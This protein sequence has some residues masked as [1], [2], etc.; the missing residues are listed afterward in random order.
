MLDTMSWRRTIIADTNPRNFGGA[1]LTFTVARKPG[2]RIFIEEGEGVIPFGII[3]EY[4]VTT[5]QINVLRETDGK[6]MGSVVPLAH[7]TQLD[8]S[9]HIE[10]NSRIEVAELLMLIMIMIL[11]SLS[12]KIVRQ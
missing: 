9:N 7:L 12:T 1:N 5:K 10:L 8:G 6:P 3:D 11:Y 4:F 2:M